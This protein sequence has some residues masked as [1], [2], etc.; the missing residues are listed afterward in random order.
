MPD[1]RQIIPIPFGPGIARNEGSMIVQPG[2]LEDVRNWYLQDGRLQTRWGFTLATTLP[3]EEWESG[4]GTV[5]HILGGH[6]LRSERIGLA[7]GFSQ[8][9]RKVG[10]WRLDGFGQNP[11]FL[12]EW[13]THFEDTP[14]IVHIAEVQGKVFFAHDEPLVRRRATTIGYGGFGP[15]ALLLDPLTMDEGESEPTEIKFRGVVKHLDYLFGWGF[16]SAD[17]DRPEMVRSSKPGAPTE[18]DINHYWIVGNRRDPVWRC[19][20]GASDLVAFKETEWHSIFGYSRATF[21]QVQRDPLYGLLAPRLAVNVSGLI[22][23]WSNEG[24][25]FTDGASPSQPLDL[26]LDLQGFEP[27]DLVDQGELREAFATYIPQDRMV[28]FVFGRRVYSLSVRRT[29]DWKWGYHELGFNPLCAFTLWSPSEVF[30]GL[31]TAPTGYP[32]WTSE[33]PAGTYADITITHI[34]ADGDELVELWYRVDGS[35]EW[36]RATVEPISSGSTQTLRIEGL[37]EG[38]TYQGAVRYTRGGQVADAYSSSDP[39]DWPTV[40]QGTFSTTLDP[41]IVG[42]F[43]DALGWHFASPGSGLWAWERLDASNQHIQFRIFPQSDEAGHEIRLYRIETGVGESLIDTLTEGVDFD[44]GSLDADGGFL[45]TDVNPPQNAVLYYRATSFVTVESPKSSNLRIWAGPIPEGQKGGGAVPFAKYIHFTSA[46][47]GYE[48]SI[49]P[50]ALQPSTGGNDQEIR[51]FDNW[52]DTSGLL[53]GDPTVDRG[54]GSGYGTALAADDQ[55]PPDFGYTGSGLLSRITVNFSI[56]VPANIQIQV[57]TR[58]EATRFGVTDV[59]EKYISDV[60]TPSS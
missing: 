32:E 19:V 18:F 45:Y 7:V 36:S 24:P 23:F 50:H 55:G 53:L 46:R 47:G 29:G 52:D 30:P 13:F 44:L 54:T 58:F 5:T 37:S 3:G 4:I 1:R 6:A 48:R 27:D 14:P 60:S 49:S 15:T 20:P 16:G 35:G 25:R 42:V 39:E 56:A 10:V 34:E 9:T 11:E 51:V 40:S 57:A 22:F 2:S 17:E 28:W 38:I 43:N 41:P 26:P 31:T 8:A 12:G 21:G 33:E 59:S